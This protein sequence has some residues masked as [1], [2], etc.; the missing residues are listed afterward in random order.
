ML[1]TSR[2]TDA[3]AKARA[4]AAERGLEYDLERNLRILDR[5]GAPAP[6]RCTLRPDFALHSFF[7]TMEKRGPDGAWREWFCGGLIY[8]GPHDGHGSG[9]APTF[10]V[11]LEPCTG[12]SIHT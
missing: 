11:T 1:D 8:H 2:V 6:T 12:W 10:A 7:F 9:A 5:F 4:H 3:L